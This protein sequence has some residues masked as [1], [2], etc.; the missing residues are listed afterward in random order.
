LLDR[1]G[2]YGP[3]HPEPRFVFP[4]HRLSRVRAIKE[5]HIRCTLKATDGARIEACAFRVADT[6]LGKL[7][8]KGEGLPF[9]VAG[10]LRRTSWQGRESVELMIED[11]ADPRGGQA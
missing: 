10:H 8:L 9:H 1:A 5:A 2:P 4:A 7:L 3:G 6:P 11:A